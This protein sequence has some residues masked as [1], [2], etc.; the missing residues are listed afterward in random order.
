MKNAQHSDPSDLASLDVTYTLKV[1]SSDA[2]D[3]LRTVLFR[4]VSDGGG[5]A[6]QF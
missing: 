2:G 1:L 3:G 4:R 6:Y 5:V